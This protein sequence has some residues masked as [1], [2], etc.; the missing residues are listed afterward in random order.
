MTDRGER[1]NYFARAQ[2]EAD[3][4]RGRFA[5]IEASIVTGVPA[6]PT[7][8]ASSPWHHDPVPIEPPLG[9]NI[10]AMEP[11]GT[12]QEI[13]RSIHNLSEPPVAPAADTPSATVVETDGSLN[14]TTNL[15]RRA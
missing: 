10:D 12:A 11:T 6:I 2:A 14:P 3:L 7:Q 13:E 9:I 15:R 5:K 1:N 8:P 4:A